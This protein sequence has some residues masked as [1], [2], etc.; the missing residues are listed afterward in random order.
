MYSCNK[1]RKLAAKV[2][3]VGRMSLELWNL[4]RYLYVLDDCKN[5]LNLKIDIQ[6]LTEVSTHIFYYICMWQH[7]R[8]YTL[9]QYKVVGLQ[10]V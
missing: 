1:L 8:N 7:W 10:L 4:L 2:Q 3:P 6:Y 9:L 5:D